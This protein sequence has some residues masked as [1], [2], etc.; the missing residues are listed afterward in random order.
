MDFRKTYWEVVETKDDLSQLREQASSNTIKE[1]AGLYG[2]SY[3]K[4]ATVLRVNN[5][6]AKSPERSRKVKKIKL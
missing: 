5:V 4:M 6:K 1:L 3:S 2:V